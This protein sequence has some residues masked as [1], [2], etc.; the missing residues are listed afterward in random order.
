M[1]ILWQGCVYFNLFAWLQYHCVDLR[2][3][4]LSV[5]FAFCRDFSNG[6]LVAEIMSWYHPQD[7]QMHSYTNGTSISTKL[8]NWQQLER[9]F[10]KHG[11]CF[12]QE[13]IEGTVHCKPGAATSL[14]TRLYTQLTHRMYVMYVSESVVTIL[15]QF[16]CPRSWVIVVYTAYCT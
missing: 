2:I 4:F 9:I 8:G 3:L 6:Y 12:P 5:W 11:L 10:F 7:I 13:E 14:V 16:I 1:C 15:S